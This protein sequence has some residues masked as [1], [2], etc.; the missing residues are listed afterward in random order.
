MGRRAGKTGARKY[1]NG[2]TKG[3]G[4]VKC[5]CCGAIHNAT[6]VIRRKNKEKCK[7]LVREN[8]ESV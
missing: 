5:Y 1:Y 3:P 6:R 8:N 2:Y 4:G 7:A